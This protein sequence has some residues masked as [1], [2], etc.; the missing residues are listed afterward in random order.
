MAR[1][2]A[3][4]NRKKV[5]VNV[6]PDIEEVFQGA[7]TW[8]AL[9]DKIDGLISEKVPDQYR[10]EVVINFSYDRYDDE[11]N[12]HFEM[13]YER[14]QTDDEVLKDREVKARMRAAKIWEDNEDNLRFK[15]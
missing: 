9:K 12:L 15:P 14:P 10:S 2:P 5:R 6:V 7:Q 3:V 11:P 1:L 4:E 8:E 13:T